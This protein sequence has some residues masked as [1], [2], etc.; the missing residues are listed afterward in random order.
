MFALKMLTLVLSLICTLSLQASAEFDSYL[1]TINEHEREHYL[2]S[3]E[4]SISITGEEGLVQ[5]MDFKAQLEVSV[6]EGET[7]SASITP[8]YQVSMRAQGIPFKIVAHPGSF[9]ISNLEIIAEEIKS[10]DLLFSPAPWEV[11]PIYAQKLY[12]YMSTFGHFHQ[13]EL[14]M[15]PEPRYRLKKIERH[16]EG[17]WVAHYNNHLS[18]DGGTMVETSTLIITKK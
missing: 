18:E 4:S 3:F 1:L 8:N 11:I 15:N 13:N 10:A 6:K 2:V 16:S 5:R 12:L 7:V 14:I 17:I 9:K